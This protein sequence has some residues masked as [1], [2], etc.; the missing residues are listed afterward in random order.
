MPPSPRLSARRIEK[1]IFDRDDQD[2]R[3]EDQ[4]HHA[5]DRVRASARR[6]DWWLPWRLPSARRVGWCRISPVDD[7]ERRR[8]SRLPELRWERGRHRLTSLYGL[9][10]RNAFAP[11]VVRAG[12]DQVPVCDGHITNCIGICRESSNVRVVLE[13]CGRRP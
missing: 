7:A 4:R 12:R 2:Q 1:R 13:V 6:R 3:P 8:S 11:P 9:A 5:K 10:L